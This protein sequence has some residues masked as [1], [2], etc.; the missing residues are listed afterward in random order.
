VPLLLRKI[1]KSKWHRINSTEI[2]SDTLGD[3]ITQNNSLSVWEINEDESNI[4]EIIV[5]LACSGDSIS[6]IDYALFDLSSLPNFKIEINEGLTPSKI[7]NQLHRDLISLTVNSIVN[8][9][10]IILDQSRINRVPD[11]KVLEL[12][13]NALANNEIDTTMLRDKVKHKLN[14]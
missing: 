4:N 8:L 2:P 12:V 3:L 1:R 9:T 10:E 5:A 6:N 7:A 11:K 14:V 13:N